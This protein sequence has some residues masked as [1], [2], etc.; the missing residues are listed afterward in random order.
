MIHNKKKTTTS[1]KSIKGKLILL[2]SILILVS[3]S[4][5]GLI[6]LITAS[7]SLTK[8]AEESLAALS[9]DAANLTE[10]RIQIQR[11]SLEMIALQSEIKTMNWNL[12]QPVLNEQLKQTEFVQIG[13]LDLDGKILYADGS[14][15]TIVGTNP[16]RTV[17]D[18]E[19]SAMDFIIDDTTGEA[20]LIYAIPIVS[21]EKIV[22]ALVGI[23][24]GEALSLLSDEAGYGEEG[25]G[26]VINSSGTV[27]AHPDRDKVSSQFNPIEAAVNEPA[28]ASCALLIEEVLSVKEGV[29]TYSYNGNNLYA[30][31]A[32][33]EG[34]DWIFVITASRSEVLGAV[35]Q[36]MT[37]ILVV[38]A[39]VLL[40]SIIITYLI[41]NSICKPIIEIVK[42]SKKISEL[43]ITENIPDVLLVK[44][45]EIGTLSRGLQSV[46]DNLRS[47]IG[48]VNATSQSVAAASEELTATTQ[49]SAATSEQVS[50]AAED[51]ANGAAVQ[52]KDI[53]DGVE[54]ASTLGSSIE[55]DQEY[56][57]NLNVA[58]DK[59]IV[60]VKEGLS[61][62]EELSS[63]TDENNQAAKEIYDVI[64]KT[65]DSSNRIGEASEVIAS[66]AE[67]TNLLSLNA[68][69]EAA[70]AGDAGRGFAVVAEE[71]KK[72]AEQSAA[73]TSN[74]DMIVR[75][76]QNNSQN[77]VG[78]IQKVTQIT[79]KQ[80]Q[81]VKKS[82]EKFIV[83]SES[84]QNAQHVV[85]QL[86]NSSEEMGVM[87]EDIINSL[88][89]LSAISEENSAA[90][91]EISAS[92]EEQA[93]TVE[94]IASS[95]EG[96]A[97][98]AENLQTI[99]QR[100]KI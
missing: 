13:I 34:T 59:S 79:E 83:I 4:A 21:N 14:T 54:K 64:I 27:I 25:Y 9:T 1:N 72:L 67:Q 86:N 84:M 3:S 92:M 12:Q 90:T 22:G 55:K 66:I 36:L 10:S 26:Y 5:I 11:R 48:E 63:I 74:I 2:F 87:K 15:D 16:I 46:I 81:N 56:I 30:G 52:A 7:S 61:V 18:G 33:I 96:L 50:K 23:R 93:A 45:D 80:S 77:A 97:E 31:Y 76:L 100:F 71:I 95:S 20:L 17:L 41:G 82:R 60:A 37:D 65:N 35:D 62:I 68:S 57:R 42:Q 19:S 43:D 73:S 88:Q 6:S 49:Q 28:L 39:I 58:T 99:I 53:E 94:E 89:N 78:T 8:E 70:R 85:F 32:P 24:D 40:I 29:G 69:I 75:E 98:M 47:I 38:M 44:Q 91:Q 51:M